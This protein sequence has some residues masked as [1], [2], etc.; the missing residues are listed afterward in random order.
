M[1][2]EYINWG[3][4]A[5]ARKE[6]L[7]NIEAIDL[8]D[9]SI[10]KYRKIDKPITGHGKGMLF[11]PEPLRQ[12]VL[13]VKRDHP[14]AQTVY[15]TPQGEPFTNRTA[16][17]FSEAQTL[18]LIAARYEG[19]DARFADNYVDQWVST[20][21]FVMTGGELPALSVTDALAR[22]LPG[23]IEQESADSDSFESGLLEHE[24][25]TEPA[26]FENSSAPE[27][28][29]SGDH[30]KIETY[31]L[32]RSLRMTYFHRPDLFSLWL[33]RRMN[34]PTPEKKGKQETKK[35]IE[36]L[37]TIEKIAKEWK[38]AGRNGKD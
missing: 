6:G 29:K 8:R 34:E 2:R 22:F 24:H 9:F 28:L 3:I 13:S 27:V 19:I 10:N 25:F 20:G 26:V 37:K 31:R 16:R 11:E 23:V 1:I 7:L 30:G 14:Q 5:R 32:E 17:R 35:K 33:T 15:L 36:L 18:I 12:A 21:D 4:L 38:D